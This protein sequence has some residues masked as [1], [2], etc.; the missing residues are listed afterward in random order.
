MKH[1]ISFALLAGAAIAYA[2][3]MGPFFFGS[4]VLGGALLVGA[5]ALELSFWLRIF[6]RTASSVAMSTK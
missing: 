6:R 1:L 4:P 3:G 2:G 5:V